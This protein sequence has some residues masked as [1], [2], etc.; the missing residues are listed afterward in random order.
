MSCASRSMVASIGARPAYS[1]SLSRKLRDSEFHDSKSSGSSNHPSRRCRTRAL[2]AADWRENTTTFA[3]SSNNAVRCCRSMGC[4]PEGNRRAISSGGSKGE[5]S[6]GR[7]IKSSRVQVSCLILAS[8]PGCR[9]R[10]TSLM[11]FHS[12]TPPIRDHRSES[13]TSTLPLAKTRTIRRDVRINVS[14]DNA[15]V[16]RPRPQQLVRTLQR[17]HPLGR[18]DTAVGGE[19]TPE[20]HHDL[21]FERMTACEGLLPSVLTGQWIAITLPMG[22]VYGHGAFDDDHARAAPAQPQRQFAMLIDRDVLIEAS[23]SQK[24]CA[25][26]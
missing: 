1:H 10:I 25:R 23:G 13:R 7:G 15:T 17:G 19:T 6:P 22:N 18:I 3:G 20:S 16:G 24:R 14:N 2:V 11:P 8:A 4:A 5:T 26:N 12:N 21:R 9:A